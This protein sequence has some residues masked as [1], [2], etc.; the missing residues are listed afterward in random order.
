MKHILAYFTLAFLSSFVNCIDVFTNNS[1]GNSI[2]VIKSNKVVGL[3]DYKPG[4]EHS[5][6]YPPTISEADSITQRLFTIV[7]NGTD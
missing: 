3:W 4:K 5:C 7:N 6:R 2:D 1:L